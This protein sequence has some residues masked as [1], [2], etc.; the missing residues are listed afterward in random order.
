[1]PTATTHL[2]DRDIDILPLIARGLSDKEIGVALGLKRST[3]STYVRTML[4]KFGAA[5]RAE[6]VARAFTARILVT[7]NPDGPPEWSGTRSLN[8]RW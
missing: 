8:V 3:I 6:L 1:V 5:N 2:A 4:A 7:H